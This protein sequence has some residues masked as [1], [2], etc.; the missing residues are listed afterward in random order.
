MPGAPTTQDAVRGSGPLSVQ[1]RQKSS[2]QC[3]SGKP[4]GEANDAEASPMLHPQRK[5]SAAAESTEWKRV[6]DTEPWFLDA[7]WRK[8]VFP[9]ACEV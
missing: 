2:G 4:C 1:S 5:W 3:S 7:E 6:L 9:V 8:P